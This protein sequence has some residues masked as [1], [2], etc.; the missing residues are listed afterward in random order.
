MSIEGRIEKLEGMALGNETQDRKAERKLM[1]TILADSE[2]REQAINLQRSVESCGSW[3]SALADPGLRA[4]AEAL[5]RAIERKTKT[6][7]TQ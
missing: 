5:A 1:V 6:T 2:L 7:A 4:Q 3:N